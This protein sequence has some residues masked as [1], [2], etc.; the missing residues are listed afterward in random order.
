MHKVT[1]TPSWT[2]TDADGHT[3]PYRVVELLTQVDERGSLQEAARAMGVSYR[4][5]WGLLREAEEALGA[6]LLDM[7][8]GR[9][10]RLTALAQRLVWADRRIKA[11]LSPALDSL[12]SEM[13]LEVRS[14]LSASGR[15]LRLHASHGFAIEQLNL[16]M[17]S[18]GYPI[19]LKYRPSL[20]AVA[21]MAAGSCELAGFHL[22]LGRFEAA[23]AEQYLQ[24]LKPE[25]QR[26]IHVARRRQG[27]MVQRGNPKKIY[28]IEDLARPDV[29]FVN[30]QLGSG[31]RVLIDLLLQSCGLSPAQVQGHDQT[32][33]THAAVAAYV[34]S[35]MADAGIGVE[36][37]ARRFNLEFIPLQSE[38]YML[39]ADVAS[40]DP[41]DL[42][43]VVEVLSDPTFRQVVSALPGYDGS[44]AG[45]VQT[46]A[47]IFG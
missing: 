39:L 13:E 41:A 5:M 25:R 40:L 30:R 31:T 12:S 10:A 45:Q 1:I 4:H 28:G 14:F 6:G 38:R 42:N 7:S 47:E 22:P 19:E 27:L 26:V 36:T 8:R 3:I 46:I 37:P 33:L 2:L 32:E 9:H 24:W 21:A 15:P 29:R 23:M 17:T 35:G 34:A 43:K 11:R 20:D 44:E 18:A 16:F